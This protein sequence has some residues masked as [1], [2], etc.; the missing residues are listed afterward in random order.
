MALV[1]KARVVRVDLPPGSALVEVVGGGGGGGGSPAVR[2]PTAEDLVQLP[3][4]VQALMPPG[5]CTEVWTSSL[6]DGGVRLDVDLGAH[7]GAARTWAA[8]GTLSRRP[9][10]R[11]GAR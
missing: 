1:K 4:R 11:S 8:W 9:L 3:D 7:L 2:L 5:V 6:G 10:A